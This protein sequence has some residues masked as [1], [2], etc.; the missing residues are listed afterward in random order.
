M[1]KPFERIALVGSGV[2]GSQI[3]LLSAY[4]GYKVTAFDTREK[5]FD[6][7]YNKL[8]ADLK[9]K[10]ITPFIPWKDWEK[11]RREIVFTTD[12]KKALTDVDFVVEAAT[13]D[14]ELK[15][16]VFKQMGELAPPAAI[17]ATNSS[18]LPVS[19]MEESK[20]DR[21][22]F[23]FLHPGHGERWACS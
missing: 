16:K 17:F 15:R 5:A 2:L 7:T 9:E 4:A 6:E 23:A 22:S 3:A 8:F 19:R 18:S 11:C 10:G 14:V 21:N 1:S 13:E 12:I 20:A